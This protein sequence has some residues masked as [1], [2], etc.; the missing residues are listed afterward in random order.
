MPWEIPRGGGDAFI[1]AGPSLAPLLDPFPPCLCTGS[2]SPHGHKGG[3]SH[4]RRE[5]PPL[6]ASELSEAISVRCRPVRR[7]LSQAR[8]YHNLLLGDVRRF[9]QNAFMRCQSPC[10]AR[11]MKRLASFNHCAPSAKMMKIT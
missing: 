4:P 11:S 7:P 8:P 10:R 2:P 3:V 9:R 5:L 1:G 6:S